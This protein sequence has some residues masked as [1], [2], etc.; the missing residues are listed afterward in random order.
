MK[1]FVIWLSLISACAAQ[2]YFE[3]ATAEDYETMHDYLKPKVG[4]DLPTHIEKHHKPEWSSTTSSDFTFSGPDL[5]KHLYED[6]QAE[7]ELIRLHEWLHQRIEALRPANATAF[8][9]VE[10]ND[11]EF[12]NW[13]DRAEI[14][15]KGW[16]V[17]RQPSRGKVAN[18]VAIGRTHYSVVGYLTSGKL[19]QL[20][21]QARPKLK[22]KVDARRLVKITMYTRA[23]C[24]WC[25]KWRA[26]QMPA[27][28][29]D[30]VVV[31]QV[32]ASDGLVPRFD[33]CT[34]DSCVKFVG[35]TGYTTMRD[36]VK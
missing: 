10:A 8:I 28:V 25:D 20:M 26:E 11:A 15:S 2:S 30:G 12:A 3:P 5:L 9:V 22:Q 34:D 29:A 27:A 19:R 6:H 35:Y 13:P 16:Q 31:E 32:I 14:E 1:T 7:P 4:D 36:A 23:G 33:A 24:V 18:V 21:D 17:V